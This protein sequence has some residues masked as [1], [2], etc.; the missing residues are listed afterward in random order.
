MH[1]FPE[2]Q[3]GKSKNATHRNLLSKIIP[4]KKF[5]T[6]KAGGLMD[7][8]QRPKRVESHWDYWDLE[9]FIQQA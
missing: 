4:S 5:K 1:S 2:H 7:T 8:L 9:T 3:P 6:G